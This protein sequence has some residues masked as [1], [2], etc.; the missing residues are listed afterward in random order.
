MNPN[1]S[2]SAKKECMLFLHF[3]IDMNYDKVKSA[4]RTAM[5]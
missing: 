1:I 2:K 4:V 5:R 3:Y